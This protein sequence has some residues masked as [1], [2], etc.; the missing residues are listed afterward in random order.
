M[1][2]SAIARIAA[3][4]LAADTQ[5]LL[6]V[7]QANDDVIFFIGRLRAPNRTVPRF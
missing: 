4:D 3:P 2:N 1:D 6:E 5:E 7:Y